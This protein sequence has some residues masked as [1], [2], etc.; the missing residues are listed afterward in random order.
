MTEFI[1][2]SNN[3]NEVGNMHEFL[4]LYV[5]NQ[6]RIQ[7][8]ILT[9]VPNWSDADDIMQEVTSMMWSK[10][11]DF[12]LGT[13]FV[14]WGI[15]IARYKIL[16]FRKRFGRG[17][18]HFSDDLLEAVEGSVVELGEQMDR[19]ID[20]LQKC[21]KK[22]NSKDRELLRMRYE[23]DVNISDMAK[24]IDRSERGM[25]RDMARIHGVLERCV[26]RTV[27]QWDLGVKPDEF[28][29]SS[30]IDVAFCNQE[31]QEK[32]EIAIGM[33]ILKRLD[34]NISDDQLMA[35]DAKF[36]TEPEMIDYYVAFVSTCSLLNDLS[37]ISIGTVMRYDGLDNSSPG[38]IWETLSESYDGSIN[39][40]IEP[41]VVEPEHPTKIYSISNLRDRASRKK[42]FST[43]YRFA[44]GF[45]FATVLSITLAI[46]YLPEQQSVAYLDDSY[47]AKWDSLINKDAE[48]QYLNTGVRRL[49]SGVVEVVMDHEV[50]VLVEAPGE[51]DLESGNKVFVSKGKI[52]VDVPN[53]NTGFT[54]VT[55]TARVVDLGTDFGVMVNDQ[56]ETE[57][58]VYQGSV[59]VRPN[60]SASS[61]EVKLLT[62]GDAVKVGGSLGLVSNID[63]KESFFVR[64]VDSSSNFVW[65]GESFELADVVGGGD[66]FGHAEG[67]AGVSLL[68]GMVA[69]DELHELKAGANFIP[70]YNS[71]FID[72]VMLVDKDSDGLNISSSGL[73]YLDCPD[74]NGSSWSMIL[75]D[76]KT[77]SLS[78]A[79]SAKNRNVVS[80]SANQGITF[81]LDKIRKKFGKIDIKAFD[82]ICGVYEDG[83]SDVNGRVIDFKVLV[84]GSEI[85]E[86][87]G[88]SVNT[89]GVPVH[90]EIRPENKFLTLIVTS[91]GS[92]QGSVKDAFWGEPIL[93]LAK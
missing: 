91:S 63:F 67:G 37:E 28:C 86:G 8:F 90:V 21:R 9:L 4:R 20:A 74:T 40:E 10:F 62:Q 41:E 89:S 55:P 38:K 49:L 79:S 53:G 70:V 58:Y 18:V 24:R 45:I 87:N 60:S 68:S 64:D 39:D 7:S 12:E 2:Y 14:A 29:D 25:Y 46:K 6:K 23:Q 11:N 48:R 22:L 30:V 44:A 73:R 80:M 84:D 88:I 42:H 1:P 3:E 27:K 93:T 17:R 32:R 15:K 35:L 5:A 77:Y 72:G 54:V 66:G 47:N 51:F 75:A 36:R 59:A 43:F 61:N 26:K 78:D 92:Y 85:F 52:F 33:L 16:E 56:G 65:R 34:G 31:E 69:K 57:V 19:R 13:N 50:K 82:C 81:D 71:E 83:I 76:K